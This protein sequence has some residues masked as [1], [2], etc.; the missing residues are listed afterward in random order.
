[1]LSFEGSFRKLSIEKFDLVFDDLRMIVADTV[2]NMS[3]PFKDEGM[4]WI[5]DFK[6]LVLL[7]N[8]HSIVDECPT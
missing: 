5:A 8:K 4:S 7:L 6:E 1:M 3:P 2:Q